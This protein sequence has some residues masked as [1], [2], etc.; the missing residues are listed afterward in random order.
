M[1][2]GNVWQYNTVS[3]SE[4]GSTIR[5]AK[6]DDKIW[7][8]IQRHLTMSQGGKDCSLNAKWRLRI[9]G[10][11]AG[12]L[13]LPYET[14]HTKHLFSFPAKVSADILP[15]FIHLQWRVAS[16]SMGRIHAA[17]TSDRP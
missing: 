15:V 9:T 17:C 6:A 11:M 4:Y 2:I 12:G 5:E 1:Q 7:D 13:E 8:Y 3:G 10:I 16:H 14:Q